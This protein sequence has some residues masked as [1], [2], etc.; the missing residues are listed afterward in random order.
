MRS[1][2]GTLLKPLAWQGVL[3]HGPSQG[4]R[5]TFR[6][7]K[8]VSS[9]WAGLPDVDTA[10]RRAITAYLGA[11][12]PA[13]ADAFSGWLSGGWFGK[14]VLRGWFESLGDDLAEVD[15]DG[16]RAYILA[17]DVDD[18]ASTTPTTVARLLPGFDQY[19]LGPGTADGH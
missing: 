19:V 8:D 17:K 2:W 16:E 18:L 15:V 10:A 7:P 6:H 14:R 5:A 13:T 9:R 12:G 11:Y 1:G 4:T 3:C